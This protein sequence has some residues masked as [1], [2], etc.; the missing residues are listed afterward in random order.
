M[1]SK[2]LTRR[3]LNRAT[4]ER[5]LLLS[6]ARDLTAAGA[7]AYLV[8]LQAQTPNAPYVALWSRLAD[9]AHRDLAGLIESRQAVR[10]P[11]MRGT[12]HLVTA[13]DALTL[14]PLTQDVLTRAFGGQA[15]AR[16]LK[17][18]DLDEVTEAGRAL[19]D[20]RPRTRAELGRLLQERWPGYDKESLG[21]AITFLV[22]MVQ[23]PPRGLW[24]QAGP[25]AWAPAETW[26]GTALSRKPE[27]D[28]AVLRYLRAFGPA[29]A[30]DIRTWS[31]LTGLRETVERLRPHLRVFRTESGTE[32]LDLPDAPLPDP[33]TPAPPRFLPEY[34]NVLL[35]Y[36][37][38][39]RMNPAGHQ[40]PLMAGNGGRAGTFL[41]GGEFSGTWKISVSP[42]AAS[43]AA[44]ST[45]AATLEIS[46]FA[47]LTAGDE[48]GL[49][50]EGARL[51]AFAAGQAESRDVRVL[52]AGH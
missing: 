41:L 28:Q 11:V 15:F 51:L 30:A 39:T 47:R 14:R 16:N 17:G 45:A 18:L 22:A 31:G 38:R 4:L 25:I 1:A 46:P 21:V 52:T 36:A 43:T 6:R 23:V 50:A 33:D 32:L 7:I 37:D 12:I 42:V 24:G 8:G 44:A 48:G 20:E 19:C 2:P 9:F 49:T 29:T 34:D 35:S 40:L 26:L 13:D 27:P 5:Q 10:I 3:A